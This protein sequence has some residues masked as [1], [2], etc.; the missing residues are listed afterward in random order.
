MANSLT[1]IINPVDD[2]SSLDLLY[3]SL[4]NIRQLLRDV[5]YALHNRGS[6]P[7]WTVHSIHASAPTLTLIPGV[8]GGDSV[9]IVAEGIKSVTGGT[10]NPPEYFTELVVKDLLKMRRLFKGVSKASSLLVQMD[11]EQ[12]ACIDGNIE[13]QAK[14]ILSSGYHCL[15]SLQGKLDAIN[16]HKSSNATIWDEVSNAPV[17]WSFARE[18]VSRVR[19]LLGKSVLVSG[20]IYYFS[21]G[22]PRSIARAIHFEDLSSTYHRVRAGFGSIPDA[23]VREVGAAAWLR[24]I[25]E[26]EEM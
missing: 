26:P 14:R 3:K 21:N 2:R 7:G 6:A 4:E 16:I 20:D 10:D 13:Q 25:R 23:R 8:S 17:R 15:G 24:S 9:R 18:E 5:D 19:E 11:N 22:V 1:F 12:V